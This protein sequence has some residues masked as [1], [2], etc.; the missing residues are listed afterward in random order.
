M[1]WESW[2]YEISSF[3]GGGGVAWEVVQEFFEKLLLLGKYLWARQ[4]QL[5]QLQACRSTKTKGIYQVHPEICSLGLRSDTL[6]SPTAHGSNGDWG[7]VWTGCF[8]SRCRGHFLHRDWPAAQWRSWTELRLQESDP[9]LTI[10]SVL[11]A[12][13]CA[14]VLVTWLKW[15]LNNFGYK[16]SSYINWFQLVWCLKL[17]I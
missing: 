10:L 2:N 16:E 17:K 12:E 4:Q 13:I 8:I 3:L 14:N 6:S 7:W 5:E 1:S 11:V 15:I 9:V